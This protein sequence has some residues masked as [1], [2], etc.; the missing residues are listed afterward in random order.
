MG[1]YFSNTFALSGVSVGF[2]SC[3]VF[4]SF[5]H[6]EVDK[7]TVSE[8]HHGILENMKLIKAVHQS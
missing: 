5:H 2:G 7:L 1:E 3:I 4:S 8:S 6:E